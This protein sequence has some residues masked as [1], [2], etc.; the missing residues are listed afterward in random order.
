M[1]T[2]TENVDGEYARGCFSPPNRQV[3]GKRICFATGISIPI[4]NSSTAR[5]RHHTALGVHIEKER[6]RE[7]ER[8]ESEPKSPRNVRWFPF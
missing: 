4:Y 1:R 8:D 5:C 7:R 2:I 6:E 3:F